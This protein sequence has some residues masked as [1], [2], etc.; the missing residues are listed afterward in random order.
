MLM[1]GA[2]LQTEPAAPR[3]R[4][5][6]GDVPLS[7]GEVE[8]LAKQDEAA[9]RRQRLLQVREME[10][11]VA[12]EVTERYRE[13]LR[14]LQRAKL[15]TAHH[16]H[17]L[18]RDL[19]LSELHR[20]YQ[21]SLQGMGDA[22]R[23]ARQRIAELVEHAQ[24]EHHKWSSNARAER[25]R[26]ANASDAERDA[27]RRRLARRREIEI[28]LKRLKELSTKHRID[29]NVRR[30]LEL[31]SLRRRQHEQQVAAEALRRG[32]E[33]EVVTCPK[34]TPRD[35]TAYQF[36]RTHCVAIPEP[37][38]GTVNST[39]AQIHA[40]RINSAHKNLQDVYYQLMN[41][42]FSEIDDATFARMFDLEGDVLTP[43]QHRLLE[44]LASGERAK[45]SA[46]EMRER[47]KRL[48]NKLPEVLERKR[49]EEVLE[50]RR[51]RLA[52]MREREKRGFSTA[53]TPPK[54]P[55]ASAAAAQ[56]AKKKK[57]DRSPSR[58]VTYGMPLLLFVVGG[59]MTLSQFVG[60]KYEARD[61][62]IKSQST[63]AFDLE[64]EH[65]KITQKLLLD[66]FELK[67]V[68]RPDEPQSS[69]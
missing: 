40:R 30:R 36:T 5:R 37:A 60:G 3:R 23:N 10:R 29:A 61:H 62:K 26:F 2:S 64:E 41:G 16:E 31:E 15:K 45:M 54:I 24:L 58:F 9:R 57:K 42:P 68:P 48:Y 66:D 63:R 19:V 18:Q 50:R 35:V 6:Y 65:K 33:M 21:A 55:H 52:E 51:Q 14:Q 56:L 53:A 38:A 32:M 12:R 59:F 1:A 28:N 8:S 43:E 7:A 46:Q 69:A 25:L 20:R 4:S 34:T 17:Q 44:R 22:Q 67:P 27:E 13:N 49:Q 47:T 11:R 39:L